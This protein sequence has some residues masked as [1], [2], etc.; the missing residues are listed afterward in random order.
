MHAVRVLVV[1]CVAGIALL[2]GSGTAS[3]HGDGGIGPEAHLPRILAVEPPVPGLDVVVIEAGARLRIDNRTG[4]EIDIVPPDGGPRTVEPVIAAGQ[5]ARWADSRVLAAAAG[6]AP[7]GGRQ[8]WA[9]PLRVGAQ[10]VS[11]RGEQVWPTP[12]RTL[13]WWL[14]TLLVAA[15]VAGVGTRAV[16]RRRWAPALAGLT[17]VVAGAHLVHVLGSALVVEEQPLLGVILGAAGPAVLAWLLALVGAVITLREHSYGP[18][19]CTL[20]GAVFAL[21]TAFNANN[22]NSAVLPFAWAADL[23]RASVVLT[24]GGGFGLFLAGRAALSQVV[25][26]QAR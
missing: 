2:V 3:A 26:E 13:L 5:T 4:E 17:V 23:D 1:L 25:S 22:F 21:V 19:L 15:G 6:P 10:S 12:P 14:A 9:I 18:V 8:A 7:V 20:S 16:G 11:V 24:L